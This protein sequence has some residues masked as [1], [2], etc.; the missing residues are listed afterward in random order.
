MVGLAFDGG[1]GRDSMLLHVGRMRGRQDRIERTYAA[2]AFEADQDAYRIV[3]PVSLRFDVYKDDT[4]FRL[5]GDLETTLEMA[6]SRCLEPF[7]VPVAATFDLRYVPHA[8]N[9]GEGER[10]IEEDD[11]ATAYY[12]DD[13][14][15]LGQ[16]MREQFYLALPMKPLC[17]ENCRGLCAE[18]GANLNQTACRHG[19]VWEDPRLAGLKAFLKP[20]ER[21]RRP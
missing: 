6:C 19:P 2:G 5:T 14:I 21:N 3:A 16:L 1:T 18:C 4:R 7:V 17:A 12:Q 15:Y 8:Q 9:V 13:T 10:E 11:L 20:D